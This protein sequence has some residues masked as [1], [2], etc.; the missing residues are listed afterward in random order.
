MRISDWSSDV[1]SSDLA[2]SGFGG[3]GSGEL[4]MAGVNPV[5]RDRRTTVTPSQR[6]GPSPRSG[7]ATRDGTCTPATPR[8]HPAKRRL[9]SSSPREQQAK[10]GRPSCRGRVSQYVLISVVAVTFKKKR[11][12]IGHT[13]TRQADSTQL[14]SRLDL[15]ID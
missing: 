3:G 1:C 6:T 2:C 4:S 9:P 8:L 13:T 15:T 5:S 10:I 12:D 14:K 7:G 11:N